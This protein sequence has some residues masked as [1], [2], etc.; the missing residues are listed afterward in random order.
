MDLNLRG[1]IYVFEFLSKGRSVAL[2]FRTLRRKILVF[3]KSINVQDRVKNNVEYV[4]MNN[5]SIEKLSNEIEMK[6]LPEFPR[7][8]ELKQN[9]LL[10]RINISILHSYIYDV[11]FL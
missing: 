1:N 10:Y 8:V 2:I 9:A 6:Y 3:C 5:D 11:T 7:D 4:E